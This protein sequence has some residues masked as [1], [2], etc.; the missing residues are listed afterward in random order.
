MEVCSGICNLQPCKSVINDNEQGTAESGDFYDT[1][2]DVEK[3]AG[4]SL[5]HYLA[6][7]R[8]LS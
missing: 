7:D 4:Q 8:K 1:G 5:K 3:S 6:F 2:F